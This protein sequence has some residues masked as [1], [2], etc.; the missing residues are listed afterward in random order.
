MEKVTLHVEGMSCSHCAHTVKTAV[1]TLSGV[2]NVDVSLADKTVT[3]EYNADMVSKDNFKAAIEDQ[4][5]D[6]T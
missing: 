1:E 6:V 2:A 5:Y 3:I 4:G